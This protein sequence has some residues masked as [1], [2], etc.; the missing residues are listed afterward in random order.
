MVMVPMWKL[1][2]NFWKSGLSF[3]HVDYRERTPVI[4]L[5]GLYLLAWNHLISPGVEI[6]K[7]EPIP[8]LSDGQRV[9]RLLKI[10]DDNQGYTSL[11][12]V[13]LLGSFGIKMAH[14]VRSTPS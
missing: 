3:H 6:Q 1:E 9:Q 12:R 8:T 14:T 5:G 13:W 2:G 11:P 4:W 10:V 7:C